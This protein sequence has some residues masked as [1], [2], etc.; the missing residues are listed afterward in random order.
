MFL[1]LKVLIQKNNNPLPSKST[2]KYLVYYQVFWVKVWCRQNLYIPMQA[3]VFY[4]SNPSNLPRKK[5]CNANVTIQTKF[6]PNIF[7]NK[8]Y[9]FYIE[10]WK[11]NFCCC[12]TFSH[13]SFSSS[14]FKIFLLSLA[15]WLS[16]FLRRFFLL[17]MTG[18]CD[19]SKI[20]KF[21]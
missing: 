5:N 10:K 14:L 17:L 2:L 18:I 7:S 15:M 1:K 9:L 21:K 20:F 19:T 3:L 16:S 6:F 4:Y 12:L 8:M 13:L 11:N